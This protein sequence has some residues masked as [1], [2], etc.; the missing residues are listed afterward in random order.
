[1][2]S[3]LYWSIPLIRRID[4]DARCL[5]L[6]IVCYGV[7]GSITKLRKESLVV[8]P[9]AFSGAVNEDAQPTFIY[10]QDGITNPDFLN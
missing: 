2:E 3:P 9:P 5:T 10:I 8:L 1:M 6:S 4:K 7:M